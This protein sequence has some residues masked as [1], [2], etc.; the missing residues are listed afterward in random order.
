MNEQ[1]QNEYENAICD[2][3]L[4]MS[5]A[6][7]AINSIRADVS[8]HQQLASEA[9]STWPLPEGYSNALKLLMDAHGLVVNVEAFLAEIQPQLI[10]LVAQDA[11]RDRD[12]SNATI[13]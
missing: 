13:N 1:S 2:A 7:K 8:R 10:A 6:V 4:G 5:Q 3:L 9:V 11:Q 12:H